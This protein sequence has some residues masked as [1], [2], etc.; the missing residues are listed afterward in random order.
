[1]TRINPGYKPF[2]KKQVVLWV[3]NQ[4]EME[5]SKGGIIMDIQDNIANRI[6]RLE[7]GVIVGMSSG[8]FED[9]DYEFAPKIDDAVCFKGYSGSIYEHDGNFYRIVEDKFLTTPVVN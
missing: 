2:R 1:M 9:M 5:T 4:K 8:C 7:E 3:A 6:S